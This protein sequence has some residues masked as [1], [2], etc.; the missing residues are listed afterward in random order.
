MANTVIKTI[1]QIARN[2]ELGECY[3]RTRWPAAELARREPNWRIINLDVHA[4]E[5]FEWAETADLLVL[6]QCGDLELLPVIQDRKRRGKKTIVEFG[7]NFYESTNWTPGADAGSSPLAWSAYEQFLADADAIMVT[8]AALRELFSKQVNP[9]KIHVLENQFPHD[10]PAFEGLPTRS[11]DPIKIGWGGSVAHMADFLSVA[12][13]LQE[14]LEQTPNVQLHVMG[15][16][17]IPELTSFPK[18]RFSFTPWSTLA[19][20]SA[21]LRTLSIGV[22]PLLD[23]PYNRCRSDIKALEMSAQG[24]LPLCPDAAPYR[25]FLAATGIRPYVSQQDLKERLGEYILK[26]ERIAQEAKLCFDYVRSRRLLKQELRRHALYTALM[27]RDTEAFDWPCPAGVHEIRG[28]PEEKT[29]TAEVLGVAESFL[30]LKQPSDALRTLQRGRVRNPRIPELALAE[31]KVLRILRSSELRKSLNEACTQFAQDLRFPLL[32]VQ[33][34][35]DEKSL[36]AAWDTVLTKL[37]SERQTYRRFFRQQTVKLYLTQ[38][39]A[40]PEMLISIGEQLLSLYPEAADLRLFLAHAFER[41]GELPKAV[42]QFDWLSQQAE[43]ISA[44]ALT[45]NGLDNSY[46]KAWRAAL[47]GRSPAS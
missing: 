26:P 31:L 30:K 41:R 10:L 3:F 32:N 7:E 24:V 17:A 45:L 36:L 12:S 43:I 29:Q 39:E 9:D 5:R 20:Y 25:E 15:N 18:G 19:D 46:L 34:A 11:L 28:T 27:A 22:I 21:F 13:L 47:A 2:T 37:R 33:W 44:S 38:A 1:V 16:K 4:K 14:V 6:F 40:C 42:A 8:S 23:T 35:E